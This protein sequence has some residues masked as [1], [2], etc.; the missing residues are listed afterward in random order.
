MVIDFQ[1]PRTRMVV[2]FALAIAIHEV[3]LGFVHLPSRPSNTEEVAVTTKIVF[4]KPL[5]TPRPTP[6]PTPT[7]AATQPPTPPPRVT[8]PPHATAAPV[9][10]VAGRAKG[11]PAKHR[12]GGAHRAIVKT[13]T[14]R[15]VNPLA[16]GSGTGTS[17]G[18]GSGNAPGAGGG[19]GGNGSGTVGNGN[20]TVNA[21]T[22]CGSV[23]FTPRDAPR[24]NNGTAFE[25]V[26]ATV[27][28]PDG[29]TEQER[30]P[31][32]WVYP[33][34]EVNDPWSSTNLRKADEM[35]RAG[36][37][38]PE[39]PAQLPPPGTDTSGYPTVIQYILTHTDAGGFTSLRPCP[40][41]G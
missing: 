19:L 18:A 36:G 16:A 23:V 5:P 24:Y 39:V 25:T 6:K 30:F 33:N 4:E 32:P 9:Q 14:G 1:H 20:G 26:I 11:R 10:Q 27:T 3:V 38:D 7:P 28:Y 12:G 13:K 35:A 37:P 31:Y 40:K 41:Q 22:P 34:G 2:A 21:N 15:Y 29:H 17:T 8:P